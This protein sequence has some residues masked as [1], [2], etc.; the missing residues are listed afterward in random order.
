MSSRRR[1]L[2][3]MVE[4]KEERRDDASRGRG[5]SVLAASLMRFLLRCG[6]SEESIGISATD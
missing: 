2:A 6:S 3:G 1:D 5:A 4:D